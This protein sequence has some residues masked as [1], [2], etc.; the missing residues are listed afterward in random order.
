M[1]GTKK[2][3]SGDGAV[4][5]VFAGVVDVSLVVPMYNEAEGLRLF[6]DRVAAVMA[7]T[8]RSYEVICIN[9]GSRD[10]TLGLL[11]E[12][13][14][15]DGRVKVL[16]LT[17]NF[18]KEVA[19]TAGLD[20]A[21]GRAVI[22]LDA[23]LQDPPE[24]IPH[25]LAKW[26]DGYKVVVARRASR[27]QEK[28]LKRTT[29]E[30]FYRVF[31]WISETPIPENAGDFRLMDQTVVSAL[32]EL[33]ER[34]RFM[35]GLFS[36]VGYTTAEVSFERPERQTGRSKWNYWK[37]WNYAI[38]G[39]AAFSTFPLRVWNYIGTAIAGLSFLWALV[40]LVRAAF[41]GQAASGSVALLVAILFIGGIQLI[42]L[43]IIGEYV[44]RIYVES[45]GRPLYLMQRAYGFEA[46]EGQWLRAGTVGRSGRTEAENGA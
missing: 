29:S 39:V 43:G 5:G 26:E 33:P 25:L 20:Y 30:L 35:K 4:G 31:N 8:G 14:K 13:R 23:D 36:W 22:P 6:F 3:Q 15:R 34:D 9:D 7:A 44:G 16:N 27:M 24:L 21:F 38:G 11:L 46:A 45:K 40:L 41:W 17:R 28:W 10:R 37:L 1:M 42:G 32:R 12:E 18:G 19:L 2:A